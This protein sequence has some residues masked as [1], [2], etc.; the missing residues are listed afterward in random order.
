M[1]QLL[2]LSLL[3]LSFAQIRAAAPLPSW[4]NNE[5]RS[6]IVAFVEKT[7]TAGSADFVPV[8]ERIAVFDN[9]GCLWSE[10]PLYFQAIYAF[11]R[12]KELAPQHPEWADEEPFKSVLAGDIKSVLAD[13]HEGLLKVVMGTHAGLTAEEF[14]ASVKQWLS[15]ARHPSSGMLYKD[16]IYQPMLELLAYLREHEYK[17]FIVSGGGIDFIRAYA[18]EAYGIPPEQV[19]GSSIKAEYQVIDGTPQIVKIPELNFVDDKEGKPIGIYQHIGRRPVFAAGNSDG[20]FQMLEWTL[21]GEGPRF[22]MLVH[23]TDADRE[24]AY[25][26]DSHIGQLVRGLD[27]A[28]ERGWLL[29]DMKEDW[30]VIYPE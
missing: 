8:D 13:G 27:E 21:A 24:W 26:R 9:D 29:V 30:K 4:N 6:A 16:M 12:V 22:G 11:E 20:D 19:I 17:T 10:Q 2:L 15:T 5:S 23:H 28:D 3:F 7:T 25:D 18:E 14:N 1:K